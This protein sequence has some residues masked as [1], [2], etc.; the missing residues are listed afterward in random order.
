M[1]IS[2]VRVGGVTGVDVYRSAF[3]A[4]CEAVRE[5]GQSNVDAPGICGLLASPGHLHA[6]LLIT[7]DRARD[8]LAELLPD[9][10]AGMITIF[11]AAPRCRALVADQT[12]WTFDAPT[13]MVCRD[14]RDVPRPRCLPGSPC[15]LCDGRQASGRTACRWRTR[16]LPC[17][18]RTRRWMIQRRRSPPICDRCRLRSGCSALSTERVWCVQ[19]PAR[20]RSARRRECS[21][22]IPIPTGAVAESDSG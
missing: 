11:A 2:C 18:G 20:A 19:P 16:W 21:S 17:S 15:D 3:V 6:R 5:P 12:T 10:K 13:A 22:S 1:V 9:A 7:D 4:R 14:L 8:L